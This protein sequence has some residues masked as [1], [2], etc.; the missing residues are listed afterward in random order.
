MLVG[1]RGKDDGALCSATGILTVYNGAAQLALVDE[2]S[3]KIQ[4]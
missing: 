1:P 3:V 2:N 4:K